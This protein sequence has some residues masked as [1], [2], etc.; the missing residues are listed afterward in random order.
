MMQ[1]WKSLITNGRSHTVGDML[2]EQMDTWKAFLPL[3]TLCQPLKVLGLIYVMKTSGSFPN[4]WIALGILLTVPVTVA[5][6]EKNS[7]IVQ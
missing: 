7:K 5:S 4:V 6:G 2:G 1:Y 3:D